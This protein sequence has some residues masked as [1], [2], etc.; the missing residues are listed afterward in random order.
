M[1]DFPQPMTMGN[2]FTFKTI[3]LFTT[4]NKTI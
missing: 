2:I 4:D 3:G 1:N